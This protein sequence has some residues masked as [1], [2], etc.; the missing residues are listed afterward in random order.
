MYAHSAYRGH[1]RFE[2]DESKRR[3]NL[4][5]HGVDFADAAGALLDENSLTLED[6]DA[7]DEPRWL[8]LGLGSK[9]CLLLVVWTEP[10][11][12]VIRLI[13]ARRASAGEASHY[14]R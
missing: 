7:S 5:K 6:R 9:A 4:G 3:Q 2:W 13:S 12:D 10:E 1:I 8:T 11:A 14:P